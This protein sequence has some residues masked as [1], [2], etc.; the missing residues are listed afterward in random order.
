MWAIPTIPAGSAVYTSNRPPT[1]ESQLRT[2]IPTICPRREMGVETSGVPVHG[3]AHSRSTEYCRRSIPVTNRFCINLRQ[4]GRVH[5]SD[6]PPDCACRSEHSRHWASIWS[7]TTDSLMP[8]VWWLD[9]RTSSIRRR[10]LRAGQCGI[11]CDERHA[12][13]HPYIAARSRIGFGTWRTS[14]DRQDKEPTA[15]QSVVAAHRQGRED[16]LQEVPKLP[17]CEPTRSCPSST[18]NHA[19]EGS[20]ATH[21]RRSAWSTP[22]RRLTACLSGLLLKIFWGGRHSFYNNRSHHRENGGAFCKTW[23]AIISEV[24][25]RPT[26]CSCSIHHLP[27][28]ACYL[29]SPYHGILAPGEWR[30]RTTESVHLESFP[31]SP[32]G[33][34]ALEDGA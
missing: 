33:R 20:M 34:K 8:A 21:C 1:T 15:N 2:S 5:T 23:L 13:C 3:S 9:H 31:D 14:R 32:T 7:A 11:C 4:P 24:G 16:H 12:H 22:V 19:A 6:H 30:S 26:V 27:G 10:A 29:T 18:T 25:Q 17:S 28:W